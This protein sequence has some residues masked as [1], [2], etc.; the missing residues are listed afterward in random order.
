[1]LQR[2]KKIS[3]ELINENPWWKYKIDQ[4]ELASGTKQIYHYVETL[5]AAV[6]VPLTSEDK[7][8]L[9][10]QYRCLTDRFSIEFPMGGIKPGEAPVEAAKRELKEE[11]GFISAELIQI[12]T[13]EPSN[14]V[15]KDA[16]AV[17]LAR[18][19]SDGKAQVDEQ[20]EIEVLERRPDEFADMITRGE[21]TDGQTLAAWSMVRDRLLTLV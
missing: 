7:L 17:F 11:T 19:L 16:T 21:I 6:C 3:T 13:F 15:L 1:M 20:E 12:G 8:V 10:R 4:F 18:K 5:G 14:G 9:V 2:S